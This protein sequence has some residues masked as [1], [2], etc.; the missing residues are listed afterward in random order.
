M[1]AGGVAHHDAKTAAERPTGD[2]HAHHAVGIIGIQTAVY[3]DRYAKN[4][5]G[6][7]KP[8]EQ[9]MNQRQA[10]VKLCDNAADISR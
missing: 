9:A 2:G 4:F 8:D 3:R 7:F 5:I 1:R 10:G 6:D